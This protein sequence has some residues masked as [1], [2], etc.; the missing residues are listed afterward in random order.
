MVRGIEHLSYQD[1]LRE[2][3]RKVRRRKGSEET[4]LWLYLKG[5]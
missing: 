3:A 4:L 2:L 5:T 1:C